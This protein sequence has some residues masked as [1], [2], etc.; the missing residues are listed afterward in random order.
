MSPHRYGIDGERIEDD[1]EPTRELDRGP[2]PP[3]YVRQVLADLRAR[4]DAQ[5]AT[6]THG[7]T[8]DDE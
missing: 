7:E 8:T 4:L 2:A 1:D 6:Q 5:A 3:E